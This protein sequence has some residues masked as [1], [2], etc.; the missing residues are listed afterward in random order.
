[1]KWWF[2]IGILW[3]SLWSCQKQEGKFL[4][5]PNTEVSN[6]SKTNKQTERR[7]LEKVNEIKPYLIKYGYNTQL[8]MLID[9]NLPSG[10][11]R[12]FIYDAKNE[13]IID[14]GLVAHGSGS[15]T[16]TTQ[17]RFSNI[18]NSLQS[19]LGKFKILHSY[20]GQFG[21]A[22]RLKGLDKTNN[23]AQ[24]RAIVLHGHSCVPDEPQAQPICLSWGCPMLSPKFFRKVAK[25]IDQS[26]QPI[27]L[28]SYY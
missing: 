9:Y 18:E 14:K 2:N 7:L 12:F 25:Y 5:I 4:D 8:V 6:Y 10:S 24:V 16:S 13:K 15:E 11:P 28:Y 22:Y 27:L 20:H 21:K 17:L 23:R 19:S 1:M 3:M 26:R